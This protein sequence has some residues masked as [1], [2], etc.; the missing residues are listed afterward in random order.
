MTTSPAKILDLLEAFRRSKVMFAAVDLGL[1]ERKPQTEAEIRLA[2]ACVSLG[3]L[4]PDFTLTPDAERYLKRD[5][6]DTLTGYIDFSN[7][8]LWKLWGDL[9]GAVKENTHRWTSTGTLFSNF[10]ETDEALRTY[11]MG[12][13]G[14]G[15][16]SSPEVAKAFDLSKFTRLVDLGGATGHLAMAVRERYPQIS[17]A[18]LD[19][20][21]V[22]GFA[23]TIATGIDF[24]E[25]DF[26]A[27]ALP[28]ADLYSLGRILH[29]WNEEKIATLLNKIY[30]ALPSGGGLLIAEILLDDD[31]NGPIAANMQSLNMLVC[32]E[33]KERSL[34]EYEKLLRAAGFTG[35]QAKRTG[36]P[37]D[38][39]LA[40]KP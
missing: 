16:I 37:V 26:F 23:R 2:H 30:A 15:R 32:T 13:N 39:I 19:L 6:P 34:L 1:F 17:A 35:V 20:P 10:Y 33:G 8:A 12:M 36:K 11:M 27:D 22:I 5:S 7:R 25:G 14:F 3:L 4:N 18:I 40:V 9:E 29:D 31:L 24:I 21:R 38:A 28:P